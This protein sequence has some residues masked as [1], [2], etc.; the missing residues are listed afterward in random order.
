MTAVC[1]LMLLSARSA[2][3]EPFGWAQPGG[4][5]APVVLSYSFINSFLQNFQGIPELQ[6]RAATTE[7]FATWSRYAPIHFVERPDSGPPPVDAEYIPEGHPDIRIG[8]H[9]LGDALV[10]A[11][12]FFPLATAM[13]GLA[14]D[15][16]FNTDTT[17]I[18]G[19]GDGFPSIDFREVVLHEIGHALGLRHLEDANSIMN[20]AHGFFFAGA[21]QAFLLPADIAAL[22]AIYGAGV[23]SVSP[24]PEPSTLILVT[25]GL[26]ASFVRRARRRITRP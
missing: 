25:A 1:L 14:G 6:L 13:S 4:A 10:L 19:F 16:H 3:A 21:T 17:H 12:A 2:H 26:V 22:Q 8:A 9:D 20:P 5:G 23:G 7:A 18:W 15:I 11:H 24:V